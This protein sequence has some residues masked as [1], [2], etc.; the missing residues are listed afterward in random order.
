MWTFELEY[1]GETYDVF[2]L[3]QDGNP[4]VDA[5]ATPEITYRDADAC[6]SGLWEAATRRVESEHGDAR[7]YQRYGG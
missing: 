7:D 5:I 3:V 6:P 2:W 4:Y 1:D